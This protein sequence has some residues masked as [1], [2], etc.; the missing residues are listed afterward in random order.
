MQG[1]IHLPRPAARRGVRPV[2]P[3]GWTECGGAGALTGPAAPARDF[4]VALQDLGWRGAILVRIPRSLKKMAAGKATEWRGPTS[5]AASASS[6]SSSGHTPTASRP[7]VATKPAS[8]RIIQGPQEEEQRLDSRTR[9]REEPRP[10]VALGLP[11][12]LSGSRSS[13]PPFCRV[14]DWARI[15][16]LGRASPPGSAGRGEPSRDR[17]DAERTHIRAVLHLAD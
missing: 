5:G 7:W 8:A 4:G 12:A 9:F 11:T 6:G 13:I 10:Q 16:P 2:K 15:F 17:Q 3:P 14:A 1:P